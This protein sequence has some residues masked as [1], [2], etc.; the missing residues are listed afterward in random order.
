MT[1]KMDNNK[2]KGTIMIIEAS[3][4]GATGRKHKDLA[5]DINKRGVV[6]NG[7]EHN[8]VSADR[9]ES[10]LPKMSG[11]GSVKAQHLA[12]QH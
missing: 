7:L 10:S 11:W 1:S 4:I 5:Q 3:A 8:A 6:I 2:V 12:L 9:F